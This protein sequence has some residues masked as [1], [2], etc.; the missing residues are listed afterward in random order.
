MFEFM[1]DDM[2]VIATSAASKLSEMS[3][4]EFACTEFI[5]AEY[6]SGELYE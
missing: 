1:D 2:Q 3:N 5:P 4:D 6:Y